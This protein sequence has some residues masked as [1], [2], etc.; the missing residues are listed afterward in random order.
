M[1]ACGYC[2]LENDDGASLCQECGT[3][4][5]GTCALKGQHAGAKLLVRCAS[6]KR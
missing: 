4:F 1:K 3:R 2:G 6:R 5:T